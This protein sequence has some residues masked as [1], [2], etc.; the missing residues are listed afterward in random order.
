MRNSLT[1]CCIFA[2][3][4]CF[5]DCAVPWLSVQHS[6]LFFSSFA[7]A[8]RARTAPTDRAAGH[9]LF[10]TRRMVH[11]RASPLLE[12]DACPAGLIYTE[13]SQ[14]EHIIT[15]QVV[16]WIHVQKFVWFKKKKKKKKKSDETW[17][18]TKHGK[19]ASPV[20]KAVAKKTELKQRLCESVWTQQNCTFWVTQFGR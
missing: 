5:S 1:L 4:Y 14:S 7:L 9:D 18:K 20:Y 15:A 6:L 19:T 10:R 12:Y 2:S 13:N 16:N 8:N 17:Q 3:S 11:L